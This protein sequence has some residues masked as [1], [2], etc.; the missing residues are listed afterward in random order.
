MDIFPEPISFQPSN[1]STFTKSGLFEENKQT[2]EFKESSSQKTIRKISY[3]PNIKVFNYTE[4][5]V[6]EAKA[7]FKK[8]V[9][10][11]NQSQSQ[12]NT[13]NAEKAK[14]GNKKKLLKIMAFRFMKQSN[15]ETNNKK[16]FDS[17]YENDDYSSATEC[18]LY[19]QSKKLENNSNM[20]SNKKI[21]SSKNS[22]FNSSKGAKSDSYKNKNSSY[23][24]KDKEKENLNEPIVSRQI[25]IL[26]VEVE[27]F[28][29][30]NE[31][32]LS[33]LTNNQ[34]N[35]NSGF[36]NNNKK[37]NNNAN[38]SS[39]NSKMFKKQNDSNQ[40]T[41]YNNNKN[42]N[43]YNNSK[44]NAY[45]QGQQA[46]YGNYSN[47]GQNYNNNP[48]YN[49]N[50]TNNNLRN[51]NMNSNVNQNF[52]ANTNNSYNKPY[53]ANNN[54]LYG[55]NQNHQNNLNVNYNT[56]NLN[57][58]RNYNYNQVNQ[59]DQG[60]NNY[61]SKAI[62]KGAYVVNSGYSNNQNYDEAY[63]NKKTKVHKGKKY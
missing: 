38:E 51:Q 47:Q 3:A 22:N 43:S 34:Q 53:L 6:K 61:D 59:Y 11:Y 12:A 9:N 39:V 24:N 18:S 32:Q 45:Y 41:G 26:D 30:A 31:K 28:F 27:N 20:K 60:L 42:L 29:I 62:Q 13:E 57:N 48:R 36:A 19:S 40:L 58:N 33:E 37:Y 16:E 52:Y 54:S 49:N 46:S 14:V 63:G 1:E 5:F 7:N 2:E 56:T 21:G 10:Y 50:I 8:N 35:N 23:N 44:N 4:E 15:Q 25:G 17:K 55:I